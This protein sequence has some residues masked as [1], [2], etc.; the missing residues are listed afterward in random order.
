MEGRGKE[1]D[2]GVAQ[3]IVGEINGPEGGGGVN[4]VIV[5][6]AA[7]AAAAVVVN[8]MTEGHLMTKPLGMCTG[9]PSP[10]MMMRMMMMMMTNRS[11]KSQPAN[12]KPQ[13]L[14]PTP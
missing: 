5:A 2:G 1:A 11:P 10:L 12:S 7:A 8:I 9:R 4:C 6:A 3:G 14:N 13:T